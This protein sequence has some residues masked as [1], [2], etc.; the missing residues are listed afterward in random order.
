MNVTFFGHR[1][2]PNNI[3]ESLRE[4]LK[5]LIEMDGADLFYVG[6][7]GNFDAMVRKTL[8]ALKDKYPHIRCIVVL[9]YM[10]T[11]LD[12]IF[13]QY[14]ETLFPEVLENTPPRFAISRRNRWMIEHSNTVVTYVTRTIGGAA[15]FKESAEKKDKRV[16]NIPDVYPE[17]NLIYN[18]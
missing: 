16:I 5:N 6:N 11:T 17:L 14:G 18:R 9:A 7:N 12:D 1:D 8:E 2:A 10:P 4:I 13:S 15:Q 3:E